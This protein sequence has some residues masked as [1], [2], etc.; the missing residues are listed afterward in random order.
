MVAL[1]PSLELLL[2]PWNVFSLLET[3]SNMVVHLF[4]TLQTGCPSTQ[5]QNSGGLS[6]PIVCAILHLGRESLSPISSPSFAVLLCVFFRLFQCVLRWTCRGS[7]VRVCNSVFAP[8]A[9][10][11]LPGQSLFEVPWSG[12]FKCAFFAFKKV[13]FLAACFLASRSLALD[14]ACLPQSYADCDFQGQ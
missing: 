4:N 3:R 14:K 9:V 5:S 2:L 11:F 8:F 7:S 10:W 13:R 12:G 1:V 6:A